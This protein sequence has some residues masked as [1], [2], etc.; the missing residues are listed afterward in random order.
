MATEPK[1]DAASGKKSKIGSLVLWLVVVVM[2]IGGGFATPLLIAQLGSG[3]SKSGPAT[4]VKFNPNEEV[5]FIDFPEIVAVLG[6]SN[7]SRYLKMNL[8]LQ[9][10][11]SQKSTVEKRMLSRTAVL[12]NRIISHIAEIT[13]EDLAGQHGHNQLRRQIHGFFNEIL[14]DDGIERIQEVLFRE[15]QV[16]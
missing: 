12:R 1:S 14:F 2:S 5:E 13:E 6:K 8:S 11:R 10:P 7:F 15:F 3:P 4:P 16:Q 9:V